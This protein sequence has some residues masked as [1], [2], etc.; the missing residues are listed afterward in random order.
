MK[1]L[2]ILTQV[3][4]LCTKIVRTLA[5]IYGLLKAILRSSHFKASNDIVTHMSIAKQRL[6]KHIPEVT[7]STIEEHPL[8]GKGPINNHS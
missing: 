6:G 4:W 3:A 1:L 7:L 5:F 8:L 2:L